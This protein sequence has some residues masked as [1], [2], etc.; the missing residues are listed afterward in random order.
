M[1]GKRASDCEAAALAYRR[2]GWSVIPLQPGEKVP[3][4][5]WQAFQD[6]RA[7]DDEIRAWF[8]RWPGINLG[9]VTGPVSGLV[10]LD[11]DPRHGGDES[12]A[13]W[14]ARHGPLP[15]T[16]EALTGGGGRHLYFVSRDPDLRNRVA[17]VPGVDLRARGGMIVAPPSLHPSGRRYAWREGHA[18]AER[19][20]A[21]LPAWLHERLGEE[22][23]RRGHPLAHWRS[24]VREGVAQGQRN[25]TIASFAGHLLWHGVDPEIVLELLLSWNRTRCRPPLG[26]DEVARVVASI[27][28][29]HAREAGETG[30]S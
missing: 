11:V 29:L 5:V 30:E 7:E 22:S 27:T 17:V 13:R 21:P 18:P 8:R 3:K 25:S 10:V 14:Q 12:L 16:V 15:E 24:L 23:A 20:L 2:L 28:K 19:P 4:L 6:R 9:I 26:D 1:A